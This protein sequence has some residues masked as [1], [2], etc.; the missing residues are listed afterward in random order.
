MALRDQPYLPLYIQDFLT[1]EKLIECSAQATGV[2][3][4]LMCIMHKSEE[5]GKILLRQK[6]KQN[7]EQLKNFAS[8]LAKQMPYSLDVVTSALA[9]LLAEKVIF[10]EGDFLCQKRM[11]KDNSVSLVRSQAGKKGGQ[12]AQAK[13]RA[14]PEANPESE[15]ED[16]NVIEDK[17][18]GVEND[19]SK[20]DVNGDVIIF[21][22][23]TQSVREAW[24]K[25]KEYR[26]KT[27]G[28]T[29]P[30]YGEQ[31]ALRQLEGMNEQQILTALFKAIESSWLNLYPDRNGKSNG[32]KRGFDAEAAISHIYGNK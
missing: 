15:I 1:D 22:V 18:K 29:Y 21:P 10:I 11:I 9:E 19:F 2:Y 24:A 25:W 32:N 14:K 8:K 26:F 17:L 23:D 16:E 4:R 3:V 20:P 13:F 30:M 7:T 27:H 6:D 31:A 12:F 28:K 5:Y